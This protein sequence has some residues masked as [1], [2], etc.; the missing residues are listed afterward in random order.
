[1]K[2]CEHPEVNYTNDGTGSHNHCRECRA[3]I[4]L[5]CKNAAPESWMSGRHHGCY[6]TTEAAAREQRAA[7]EAESRRRERER[8]W[9][10][11]WAHYG[12]HFSPNDPES[13][14]NPYAITEFEDN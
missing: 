11:G 10:E 5:Y 2:R 7:W 13:G 8:I 9:N 1:M 4:C 6:R 14:I 3:R 12:K